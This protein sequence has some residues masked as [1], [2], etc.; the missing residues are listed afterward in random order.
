MDNT[1]R[2]FLKGTA[3]MGAA[4]MAAGCVSNENRLGFG[5]GGSMHGFR[6]APMKRVRVGV[7]GVGSRGIGAVQR[8][9][10]IPGCAVTAISDINP[11]RL[12]LTQKWLKEHGKPAAKEWSRNGDEEAWKGLCDSDV[13]DVVYSVTPRPLH[14]PIN[15]YAMAH[16]KHVLQ[17]VP[18]AFSLDE[19][20]ETVEACEK[21]RRHCMMLENCTYGEYEMLA[22]TLAHKGVLGEIMQAEVGYTHDQR[23]LQYNPHDNRFWRLKRHLEQHGN[24]Y[25][26]HG[27]V[28]AGRVMDINRGDRFEYLVSMET[29]SAGF[30]SY[31]K[32]NFPADD[33]RYKAK[34]VR[35]DINMSMIHTAMGKTLTLKHNVCTPMPYDR[36]NMFLGTKGV[37]RS[38]PSL[39]MG[40]EKKFGDGGAHKYFDAEKTE[41]LRQ[42][43]KHPFW[44]VAGE[45]A[46]KVGGHGGMDFIMDLRWAYCLQNGLPLDTDVYDLA[47]YSSI[48]ELTE[49]SVNGRS[50]VMEF[51]DYTKGGWKTAKAFTIDEIDMNKFDFGDGVQR[52]KDAQTT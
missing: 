15:V 2:E 52:A 45:I 11:A 48:V 6:T 26:T 33:W 47:T 9:A 36:G 20:W 17:E 14:T 43:Y 23:G 8:I 28:P 29:K 22:F 10:Q 35:G 21:Y 24:Y 4:A 39:L 34:M 1:R 41:K 31:A 51:P 18:G 5:V 13:C 38:Y 16:G 37:F 7:I 42:E 40:W 50:K 25:P 49:R 12:D 19:C 46:K 27:L 30:E 32:A 44:K 3:W